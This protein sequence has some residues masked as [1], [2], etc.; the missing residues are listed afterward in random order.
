MAI[1]RRLA[2]NVIFNSFLKALSTVVLSL[3]LVRLITGYLGQDGFGKYAT[4]LA[5]FAFFAAIGDL[6]LGTVAAREISKHGSDERK[7]LGNIVSLRLICSAILISV[8][9]FLLLFFDYPVDVEWG[10]VIMAFA[11]LFSSLSS[12]VNSVFQKRIAM[13]RV[14]MV[15][16]LGKLI[17]VS[18]IACIVKFDLGF[19]AITSSVLVALAFNI[20]T[21]FVI[22]RK[23][24]HFSLRFEKDFWIAFLRESLP[25]GVTAVITF[26]YFKTDIILLSLFQSSSDVGIYSVAYKIIENLIF[27]PAMLAGLILPLLARYFSTNKK[28]FIEI[29]NKTFKVFVVIVLPVVIGTVFLASDIV[30]IIGGSEFL[31][32][33]PVLQILAFSLGCIF[34]G[35]YFNMILVVGHMQKK[36]MQALLFIAAFN[37]ILNLFLVSRYSYFGAATTAVLTEF[38]VVLLT[39]TLAYRSLG[40]SPRFAGIWK[41]MFSAFGMAVALFFLSG[42]PFIVSGSISLIVYCGLLWLTQAVSPE[43]IAGLFAKGAEEPFDDMPVIS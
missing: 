14:A 33:T 39:G 22:S 5:F 18:L 24:V 37:I 43:E 29:A 25:M 36:L 31:A 42:E 27:F 4:T 38:M 11:S 40:F 32:S 10:I 21:V 23:F 8:S 41:V 9:P 34:F 1:A 19:L 30:Q 20:M 12:V 7:I 13:D 6:G 35:Q 16:F 3:F 26:A 2:Y 15:E 17:Q 28:H